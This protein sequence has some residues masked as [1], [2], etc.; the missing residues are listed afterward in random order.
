MGRAHEDVVGD[1]AKGKSEV[2]DIIFCAASFREITNV[3]HSP[4]GC[5]MQLKWLQGREWKL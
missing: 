3:N 2:D 1:F 4:C 5:F